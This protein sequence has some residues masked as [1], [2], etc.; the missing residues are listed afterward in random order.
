LVFGIHLFIEGVLPE[1]IP[2]RFAF[3]VDGYNPPVARHPKGEPIRNPTLF[4][5]FWCSKAQEGQTA[6]TY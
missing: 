1:G 3:A 5:G 6:I 4:E 2:Y